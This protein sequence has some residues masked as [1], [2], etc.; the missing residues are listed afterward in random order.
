M[1]ELLLACDALISDYSSCVFDFA[2]LKKPVFICALDIKEYEKT[3]G[4]LPEFYDFPFPMATSNEE[5]LTNIKNYD[6]KSYFD[7][8]NRYFERYPLYDDG[9]A[10]RRVVDWLEKKI[11]EKYNLNC[12]V[13]IDNSNITTVCISSK[14]DNALAN[15]IMRLIQE[16]YENKMYIS[17]KFE[18]K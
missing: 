13:K 8:V 4:L 5:M 11:K 17:V 16:Q 15:N 6:Q 2:I 18:K 3:R 1:Q 12:F 10:S 14:H 9:N 7:K